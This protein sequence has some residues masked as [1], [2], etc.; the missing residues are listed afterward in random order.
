MSL[1]DG[2]ARALRK[3]PNVKWTLVLASVGAFI[4]VLDV[5]VVSTALPT[6]HRQLHAGL[7]ELEWTINAYNLVF[8]CLMLTGA[9]LGDRYGRRRVYSLGLLVFAAASVGCALSRTGG[10]LIIARVVEGG[11]AACVLPLT[12]TLISDVFPA[13]KQAAAIGIWGG[14]TGLGAST[15]PVIGGALTQYLSWQW[16]FWINVPIAA[17]VSV[18][19][20]R[21]MR[22]SYGPR[23]QLDLAGL[24]LVALGAFGLTWAAVRA[25]DVGWGSAEVVGSLIGGA[26]FITAFAA[27]ERRARY[28]MVPIRYFRVRGFNAANGVIFFQFMAMVGTLFM[29]TQLLQFGLG[30]GVFGAGLRMLVWTGTPLIVAPLSGKLAERFGN[31]PFM[32]MGQL[33]QGAGLVWLAAVTHAGVSYADLVAPLVVS[34][35]GSAMC[36][37]TAAAAVTMAVPPADAGV[38]SGTNNAL[39]EIGGVFGVAVLAAV[40][41]HNGGGYASAA[42]FIHGWKPAMY[43]AAI[44]AGLGLIWALSAPSKAAV[45]ASIAAFSPKEAVQAPVQDAA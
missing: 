41:A 5:V 37:P 9:A 39:R 36:F 8:A 23:P 44:T 2:G 24:A 18:L 33:L 21:K 40:F 13:E 10:E 43:A 32:V 38:A 4:A 19:S 7:P 27:W 30:Y 16:I 34:G 35:I 12:L 11:G 1:A 14:V 42:M 6:L 29:L 3:P 22:E 20:M 31:K 25:P 15:G 28:P 17:V 45:M 26:A